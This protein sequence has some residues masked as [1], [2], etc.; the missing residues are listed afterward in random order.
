LN[1][2]RFVS[3][4]CIKRD[5]TVLV[6]VAAIGCHP[7]D[8]EGGCFGTLAKYKKAGND[9]VIIV[10]TGGNRGGNKI[11][12]VKE[13][14]EAAAV[15]GAKILVGNF[16]DGKLSDDANVVSWIEKVLEETKAEVVFFPCY[17]DRHQDHRNG[18]LAANAATRNIANVLM[19]ETSST[20]DF[21]PQMFTDISEVEREKISALSKHQSMK[22][23]AYMAGEVA[24]N[25]AKYRG[26]QLRQYG[27]VVEA[28]QVIRW[29]L[30]F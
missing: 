3:N 17:N 20:T 6:V 5:E 14:K 19:Y 27:K 8:V 26:Y 12:R 9:V 28:F 7:D 23:E 1:V 2:Q 16:E 25:L 13:A 30:K 29:E 22:K 10:L 24:T 21:T 11:V 18:G 15:I 4:H